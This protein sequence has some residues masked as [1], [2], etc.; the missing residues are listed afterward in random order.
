[1]LSKMNLGDI[2]TKKPPIDAKIKDESNGATY[3]FWK[4]FSRKIFR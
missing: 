1:M 4:P 3:N 2:E